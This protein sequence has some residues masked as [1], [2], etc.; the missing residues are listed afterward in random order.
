MRDARGQRLVLIQAHRNDFAAYSIGVLTIDEARRIANGVARLPQLLEDQWA[1]N[2]ALAERLPAKIELFRPEG[3]AL[4]EIAR[5]R[6][7]ALG[8]QVFEAFVRSFP[9][10][11][12]MLS[13]GTHR[14]AL[15]RPRR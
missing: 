10:A 5:V 13:V 12:L 1:A 6:D 4:L 2:D 11:E 9:E 14:L 7:G 3:G 8:L 15:H